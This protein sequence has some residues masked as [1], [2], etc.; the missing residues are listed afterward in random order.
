MLKVASDTR[1]IVTT[2][3]TLN[4][5]L[6]TYD[7]FCYF[8]FVFFVSLLLFTMQTHKDQN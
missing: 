6:F 3:V 2:I 1:E 7:G 4:L 8:E 5:L